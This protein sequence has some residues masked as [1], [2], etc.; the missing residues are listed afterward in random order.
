MK[1]NPSELITGFFE[2]HEE[3]DN[4]FDSFTH[5]SQNMTPETTLWRPPMD[6][7]ETVES[8]VIKIEAAGLKPDED[9]Q[10]R[11]DQNVLTIRGN[12]Q[13]RT[14]LKKQHYH[15][16]E[17]NY[18]PFER[19]IALPDVL[20]EDV[21][22]QARYNGGFLEIDI[23]KVKREQPEDIASHVENEIEIVEERKE[24]NHGR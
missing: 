11:L 17:L 22:P 6:I 5:P 12:R 20:A 24:P 8:F 14:A 16:A 19:S 21:K 3:L 7:Y 13:D 10:I 18:G 23:P 1:S 4:L 2:M 15:Q 9:I